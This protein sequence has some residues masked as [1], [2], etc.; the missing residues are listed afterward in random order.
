MRHAGKR[1]RLPR[2]APHHD[3]ITRNLTGLGAQGYDP[4]HIEAFMRLLFSTLDH[5]SPDTFC[6][7]VALA[8]A[9]IDVGGVA[10]AERCARSF[11]L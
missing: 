9:C 5:L 10:R 8:C 7:E 1:A 3:T 11:G 4:R 6:R 2:R